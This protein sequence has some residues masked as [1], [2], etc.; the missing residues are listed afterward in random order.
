MKNKILLALCVLGTSAQVAAYYNDGYDYDG[1]HHGFLGLGE[2]REMR[3]ERRESGL[4]NPGIV[5]TAS[6][7][8]HDAT[9]ETFHLV[10]DIL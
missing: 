9:R 3:R 10:D 2:R 1:Y 4:R 5:G 8:T 7:V 6:D